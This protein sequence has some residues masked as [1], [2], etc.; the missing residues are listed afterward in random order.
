MNPNVTMEMIEKNPNYPW[1]W[2]SVTWNPNLTL[3]FIMKYPNKDWDCLNI[4]Y[5]E[6]IIGDLIKLNAID[7]RSLST[8]QFG[9]NKV[10]MSWYVISKH[11]YITWK[12]ILEHPNEPWDWNGISINPNITWNI[13]NDNMNYPWA[14]DYLSIHKDLTIEIIK[15][16]LDKNLCWNLISSHKNITLEIIESNPTLP[17]IWGEVSINPN[18][19][20]NIIRSN[21]NKPWVKSNFAKNNF[22]REREEFIGNKLRQWF[23]RSELK[24]EL[25]AKLWHPR[26][27]EKFK[28][29]DPVMFSEEDEYEEDEQKE[30]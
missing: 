16:N 10:N 18:I 3:E 13:I 17:W 7:G 12:F 21:P 20:F 25:I 30:K 8:I 15:K 6:R 24:E 29:Y 26:N 9:K 28:Y 11:K 5:H 14:W 27:F 4:C 2:N 22:T 19:T 1:D 23:K